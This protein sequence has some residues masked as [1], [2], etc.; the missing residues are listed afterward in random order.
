MII[1]VAQNGSV[2]E[3]IH[4]PPG[5]QHPFAICQTPVDP[6]TGEQVNDI[7]ILDIQWYYNHPGTNAKV[8]ITEQESVPAHYQ[9]KITLE[10]STIPILS[11]FWNDNG[12]WKNASIDIP[13]EGTT[14]FSA[15]TVTPVKLV[16]A[17]INSTA[18]TAAVANELAN[19]KLAKIAEIEK[20]Y[21]ELCAEDYLWTDGKLYQVS[22]D[23][24]DGLNAVNTGLYIDRPW[25]A[26]DNTLRTF[27]VAEFKE[28]GKAIFDRGDLYFVKKQT[29]KAEVNA[30]I[31]KASVNSYNVDIGWV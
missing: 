21:K 23:L 15:D 6:D 31:T 8:V 1:W 28:L 22:D 14:L 19:L 18:K 10:W 4:L 24:I 26:K 25:M 12:I 16:E 13:P 17:L 9:S 7:S 3:I 20:K 5:K 11:Q 30:L 27:T 2:K 29:K